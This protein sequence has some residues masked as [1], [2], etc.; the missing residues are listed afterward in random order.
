MSDVV[1][2]RYKALDL[3]SS[4]SWRGFKFTDINIL[5]YAFLTSHNNLTTHFIP[6]ASLIYFSPWIQTLYYTFIKPTRT[7]YFILLVRI[8]FIL[9]KTCLK[10]CQQSCPHSTFHLDHRLCVWIVVFLHWLLYSYISKYYYCNDLLLY[11][12]FTD[13]ILWTWCT[14]VL[15]YCC[16]R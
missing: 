9:S 11:W 10:P 14:I 3:G 7:S 8:T 12:W 5:I 6:Q 16:I 2:E 13:M 4:L 1:A 15:L